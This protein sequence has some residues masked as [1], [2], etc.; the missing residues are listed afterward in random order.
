[1]YNFEKVLLDSARPSNHR[2]LIANSEQNLSESHSG[3]H[4]NDAEV[5]AL[6]TEMHEMIHQILQNQELKDKI[7]E[8]K[9]TSAN[10]A[11]TTVKGTEKYWKH[12]EEKERLNAEISHPSLMLT[13]ERNN[14]HLAPVNSDPVESSSEDP[15]LDKLDELIA[16]IE[17]IKRNPVWKEQQQ[18]SSTSVKFDRLKTNIN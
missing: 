7:P 5:Q 4:I 1:M 3:K 6:V 18:E 15:F 10:V 11:S 9:Q 13:N 8:E 2:P 16:T 17:R 12:L 14:P